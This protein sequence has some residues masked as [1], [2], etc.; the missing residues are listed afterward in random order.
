MK[1]MNYHKKQNR[2][3]NK[4]QKNKTIDIK[5]IELDMTKIKKV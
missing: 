2:F 5:I 4:N 3:K 1:K